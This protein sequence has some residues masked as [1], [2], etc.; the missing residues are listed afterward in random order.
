M[1]VRESGPE[2]RRLVG[3]DLGIASR[4][5]VR[6]LEADG[7]LVCRA[8]CVPAVESL[9]AV[10]QAAL[11]GAAEGTRLAVVFE[12]TGP[13][14]MPIAVFFARRGHAVFRVSSAKA[15]DLRRFLRRHA[16]SNGT[17]AE[18]LAR[19]PLAGPRGLQPLELP[20]A[21]AAA[22]NRRIRACERLTR[23]ASEHKVRI[24]DL[25]RQLLPMTPLTGDLG[26]ADLAI[27]EQFA[28][29]QALMAAG[30]AELTRLIS[31]TSNKQQGQDRAR[32]WRAAAAAAIEL[33]GDDPAVPFDALAAEV[34]TEVRLLRAIQAELAAHAAAREKHY[35]QVDPGQL[36][37]SLPGFAEI[38]APVLVAVMGR[39]GRFR[40]GTRFKSYAGLAPRA[41]QSG[42]TDRKGQPMSKAGPSLLRATLFRAADT[43]R[44]QDPQLARVYHQQMTER[45]ANH[46]KATCVV[47]G[48]LAGR[49]WL[50]MN[51]GTPYV[52]CDS[53]GQ[54]VTAEQA[55]QIIAEKWTVTEEVRKR[56]R[57][58]K[59]AGGPLRRPQPGRTGKATLPAPDPHAP[60]P[61]PSTPL[62]PARPDLIIPGHRAAWRPPAAGQPQHARTP[63]A[64]AQQPGTPGPGGLTQQLP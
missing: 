29:P 51:R 49:A 32:Q 13:A 6:V 24:K 28:S 61:R 56:R 38:S 2:H 33:Y 17:G 47:A 54:P 8:S 48:H 9:L 58:R 11:A 19:M 21:D 36:A 40:E 60:A 18:T 12:P 34:A 1:E 23:A 55:R 4:H 35:L 45:G 62:P 46:L 59:P 42:E 39:P 27:L 22:L 37:R 25:V 15:A 31:T 44:R 63:P 41:S 50:V 26:K 5:A 52:I 57:S 20:G 43:A 30:L 14:W 10:E 7:R 16:K 53:N 3:I 64:Q